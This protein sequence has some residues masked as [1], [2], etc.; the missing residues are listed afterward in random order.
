MVGVDLRI[1]GGEVESVAAA[2]VTQVSAALKA[3]VGLAPV[4]GDTARAKISEWFA[5][6]G[7]EGVE[8][9]VW[10]TLD[11][12][13]PDQ[14]AVWVVGRADVPDTTLSAVGRVFA[15]ELARGRE[16]DNGGEMPGG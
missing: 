14:T 11:M 6:S 9:V 13:D 2:K 12:T 4:P 8:V 5:S 10:L 3:S 1:V 16:A 7:A 15:E